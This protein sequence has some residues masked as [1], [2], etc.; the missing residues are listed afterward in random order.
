M[1]GKLPLVSVIT[2]SYNQAQFLEAT[3]LSVLGQDYPNI[4]YIIIDGGSNDSSVDIIRKYEERLAYW[5][6]EPDRGQSHALNKGISHATGDIL[7]WLNADDLCLP[8]TFSTVAEAFSRQSVLRILTGQ[9][10]VIDQE[11]RLCGELRSRFTSWADYAIGKCTIRQVATFFDRK[12]FDELGG[13]DES[14]EYSM[15]FDL[16]LRFTQQYR[17]LIIDEYL[18]AYRKHETAKFKSNLVLGY[19]EADRVLM[20][21]LAGTQL[22]K[23]GRDWSARRWFVVAMS[24]GRS[25]SER[26]FCLRSAWHMQPSAF[27]SI[28]FWSMPIRFLVGSLIRK[29]RA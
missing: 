14:L 21:H 25:N 19:Q 17:P 27:S 20:K 10:H 18:A 15:D 5:V 9:A 16:L 1:K 22:E 12:L 23:A 13:V 8:D 24:P 11:G 3:I 2:P 29:F 28:H 26:L 7:F 6:S 4:E